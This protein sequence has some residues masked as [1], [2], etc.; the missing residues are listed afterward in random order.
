MGLERTHS[1]KIA[2]VVPLQDAGDKL[3]ENHGASIVAGLG[4]KEIRRLRKIESEPRAFVVDSIKH[5]KEVEVL[6]A[7][8]GRGFYLIGVL[9][10]WKVRL[11]RLKIKF[12]NEPHVSSIE[13]MMRRDEAGPDDYGQQVRK[14]LHLSDFFVA[15]DTESLNEGEEELGDALERFVQAVTGAQVVRP[16]RDEKG[17]H[18][19]W[20]ASLR[21]SCMSRQVGAAVMSKTGE[22]LATGT[23]D[24]PAPGGGLY[25]EDSRED[26]RCF[27][28]QENESRGYCRNDRKKGEIYDDIH[29][30]LYNIGALEA[31]V[32]V[33]QIAKALQRTRVRDLIEFSR[34]IHAEMDA[35]LAIARSG[36][37]IPSGSSLY[38]TAFPCHSCARHIV[39][40]GLTKVVYLEPYDKSLALELHADAVRETSVTSP[41]DASS[42]D[43]RVLLQLFTGVA[44]RRFAALFEKRRALKTGDGS[45]VR[46][47]KGAAHADPVLKRSFL[48]LE[49]ELA[50]KVDS[51]LQVS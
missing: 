9:C 36:V 2:D 30:Q 51:A 37:G 42:G 26:K 50:E 35:L 8:Y 16:N 13:H 28:W 47:G 14:T 22:V 18:A 27:M 24:P 12:K 32:T 4:I 15:N 34:A 3:R 10:N 17:M 48:Q 45:L 21:S 49:E 43:K 38:C 33:E 39:A 19:A 23:N 20:G 40:A 11:N 41:K 31:D 29:E 7:V 25:T 5:P 1:K 46:L 44:P 6:R